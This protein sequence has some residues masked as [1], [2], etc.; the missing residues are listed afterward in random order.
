MFI[1]Q[2]TRSQLLNS[3]QWKPLAPSYLLSPLQAELA[4]INSI[5]TSYKPL[6]LTVIQLLKREPTFNGMSF[7]CKYHKRSLL[8]FLWDALSWMTGTATTKDVRDIKRRVNP[9]I[10]TQIQQ[11]E[12]LVH[13]ISI[14]NITRY[15]MQV[16]RQH[17]NAV[18]QVVQR[19]HNDVTTLFNNTSS[20]YTNINY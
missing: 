1:Q 17:I 8:P 15:A 20:I 19:T 11:Q 7:L 9:L 2:K 13:A 18:I 16:K 6:I 4:N 12:T 3:L 10:K 14:L 5:Y